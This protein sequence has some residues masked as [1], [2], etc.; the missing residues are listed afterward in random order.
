VAQKLAAFLDFLILC[1]P[2]TYIIIMGF[3][4]ILIYP[5][6]CMIRDLHVGKFSM[7]FDQ[8]VA[9]MLGHG[10][11]LFELVYWVLV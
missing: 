9:C 6:F 10:I 4:Y 7:I 2:V 3:A 11:C 1:D 8:F 5:S